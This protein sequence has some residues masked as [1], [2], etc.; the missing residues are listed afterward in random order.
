[1]KG[2][3]QAEEEAESWFIFPLEKPVHADEE[4]PI[5][6]IKTRVSLL[7]LIYRWSIIE[8][9]SD[10]IIDARLREFHT[11]FMNLAT[12]EGRQRDYNSYW[13]TIFMCATNPDLMERWTFS[14]GY[15]FKFRFRTYFETTTKV[16]RLLARNVSHVKNIEMSSV[17]EVVR[18]RVPWETAHDLIC[19]EGISL[20]GG[21]V[22]LRPDQFRSWIWN[23]MRFTYTK[24][25]RDLHPKVPDIQ[26]NECKEHVLMDECE[27]I[28]DI[29]MD[30]ELEIE[31]IR[32]KRHRERFGGPGGCIT[33]IEDLA[34]TAK[35]MFPPCQ[36]R[37]VYEATVNQKHPKYEARKAFIMFNLESGHDIEDVDSALYE[38]W[39]CDEKAKEDRS[40]FPGGFNKEEFLKVF[41][42]VSGINRAM[43]RPSNSIKAYGCWGLVKK[44]KNSGMS[45]AGCP[46]SG[47]YDERP[48]LEWMG[49]TPEEVM[50]ILSKGDLGDKMPSQSKCSRAFS[51]KTK[52]HKE[53]KHP[54]MYYREAG[55]VQKPSKRSTIY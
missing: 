25:L 24:I 30:T 4:V 5:Y 49:F 55:R 47:S 43:T 22:V 21:F 42:D 14:E 16:M 20:D 53:I 9:I 28:I 1:M 15:L 36:A 29:A 41:K 50:D 40:T 2:V 38:L 33:D 8:R 54:N 35:T 37:H 46:F 51:I 7:F 17:D 3:E 19:E 10:G 39:A 48:L 31:K 13:G 27:D 34:I 12:P 6:D 23:G 44:A 26:K 52:Q 45:C 11:K 18:F 32:K